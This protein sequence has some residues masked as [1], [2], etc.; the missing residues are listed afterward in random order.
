MGILSKDRIVA[1]PGYNRWW[2]I[3][4]ALLINLSIGQA[5][6]FSVFNIP[7]TRVIGITESVPDDWHL[8][9]SPQHHP[10]VSNPKPTSAASYRA[11]CPFASRMRPGAISLPNDST[12]TIPADEN[13]GRWIQLPICRA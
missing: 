4:A 10:S 12:D 7:L 11:I 5:Y 13:H 3:P 1:E 6:A 2:N 9:T 8:S